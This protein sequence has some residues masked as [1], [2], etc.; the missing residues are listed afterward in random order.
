MSV[1]CYYEILEVSRESSFEVIKKS[2]RKLA[3]KYHP[4]RNPG[5]KEA[6]A[7]FKEA[8]EAYEVLSD[9]Q[10]RQLYD[11]YGHEGLERSGYSG[12]R[13]AEDIF[14][15]M[16]DIF[17]DLF[18][19]GR[20]RNPNG[21][22]QGNDLRYDLEISFLDAVHGLEK[23]VEI[24][25]NEQCHECDGS[26]CQPGHKPQICPQC[27]G[28]GQVLRSQGFF[29]VSTPCPQCNGQGH[30]ISRP[31]YECNGTGLVKRKRTINLSIPAGVDTGS[32]MRLSGEGEGGRR[33]GPPGDLYVVIHVAE[34]EFFQRDGQT[35][36]L[37][38]PVSMA[39]AALGCKIEV[40][41]VHGLKTLTVPEGTQSGQ[42]FVLEGEGVNSLRNTSRGDMVVEVIVQT[43]TRLSAKQ[44]EL[45]RQFKESCKK[46]QKEDGLLSR[47]LKNY[48]HKQK[49]KEKA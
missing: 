32:K 44:K 4:D 5:D 37:Q 47:F 9:P 25:K 8:A 45:L 24:E 42:Q 31:C 17:S 29:Q 23:E 48:L 49:N 39:D 18:G 36:F 20:A 27:N 13:T 12:P 33:G 14:S 46:E 22:V 6:E 43:P 16:G 41:T 19:F 15:H 28:R 34:H 7:R 38:Y 21:A 35:I 26:G 3:M 11:T 40:P 1:K 10:K 2:Y 30:I